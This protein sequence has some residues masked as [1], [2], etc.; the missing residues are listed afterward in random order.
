MQKDVT[1]WDIDDDL[2]V[3]VVLLLVDQQ[4]DAVVLVPLV[5]AGVGGGDKEPKL[6]AL[7]SFS[8]FGH[9]DAKD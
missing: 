5:K 6:S 1:G 3:G 4:E 9:T 2:A 8:S 7:T